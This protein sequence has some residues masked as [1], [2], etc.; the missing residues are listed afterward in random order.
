MERQC[1]VRP[2][3]HIQILPAQPLC[4]QFMA[5]RSIIIEEEIFKTQF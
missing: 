5:I 3:L 2:G 4:L 1:F